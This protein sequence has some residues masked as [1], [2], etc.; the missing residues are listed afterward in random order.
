MV[1]A[2]VSCGKG[3]RYEKEAKWKDTKKFSV[4]VLLLLGKL[5][6]IRAHIPWMSSNMI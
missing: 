6:H 2:N 3:L 4:Q 1:V 5:Q